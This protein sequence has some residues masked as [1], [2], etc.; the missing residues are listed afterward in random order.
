MRTS[1]GM[2]IFA[3][4]ERWKEIAP[5]LAGLVDIAGVFRESPKW[6]VV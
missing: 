4:E 1:V 3:T 2:V 6:V 5:P